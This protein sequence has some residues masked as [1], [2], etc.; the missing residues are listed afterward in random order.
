MHSSGIKNGEYVAGSR[1][2]IC[3]NRL[4]YSHLRRT[5]GRKLD[6][7]IPFSLP[8]R[9]KCLRNK[10]LRRTTGRKRPP[11][12]PQLKHLAVVPAAKKR[13]VVGIRKKRPAVS[14][15]R[16][17]I[18]LMVF[19]KRTRDV[20]PRLKILSCATNDLRLPNEPLKSELKLVAA[21]IDYSVHSAKKESHFSH[22]SPKL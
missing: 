20:N 10:Q 7:T 11:F 14:H 8:T 17:L 13:L 12:S 16:S 1:P 19:N 6:C 5:S 22:L 9:R 2:C 18:L 21:N 15:D 3:T 4:I